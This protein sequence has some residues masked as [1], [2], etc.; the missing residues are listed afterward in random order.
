MAL[1]GIVINASAQIPG[2]KTKASDYSDAEIKTMIQKA[3]SAGMS[4]GQ[5]IQLAKAR[6][7]S[8]AEVASF[9][10][11]VQSVKGGTSTP[12][13]EETNLGSL[14][15]KDDTREK[16]A[17]FEKEVKPQPLVVA[18]SNNKIYGSALFDPKRL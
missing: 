18:K 1:I 13:T 6:G 12:S 10:K 2:G 7:M 9:Q 8:D 5:V 16:N 17:T 3:E 15:Q 4:E 11:R 14:N